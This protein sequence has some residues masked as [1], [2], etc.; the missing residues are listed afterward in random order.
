MNK[1]AI[2]VFSQLLRRDLFVLMR[3]Y[4]G[5]LFDIIFVFFT[6]VVIFGYILPFQGMKEGFGPFITI[7]SIA[8]FGLFEVVEKVAAMLNDIEG[9]KTIL[10]S[11]VMPNQSW[12]VFCYIGIFWALSTS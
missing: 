1:T 12:A 5:K 6:T 3:G 7:G 11:L 2:S 10:Q 9:D 4:P 8:S